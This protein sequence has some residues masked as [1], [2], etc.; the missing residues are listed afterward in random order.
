MVDN[1]ET[2]ANIPLTAEGL[3]MMTIPPSRSQEAVGEVMEKIVCI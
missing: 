2:K 3:M 1:L